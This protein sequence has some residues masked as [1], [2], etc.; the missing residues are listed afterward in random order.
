[1]TSG[2]SLSTYGLLLFCVLTD[3]AREINFKA[4]SL[5]ADRDRY[6]A[7]LLIQPRLWL[8]IVLWA[9]ECVAW[10]LVLEQVSLDLLRPLFP[11]T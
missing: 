2:L 8:G 7:S 1:M 9:V 3:A 11:T 4:A 6:L 10:L 5:R